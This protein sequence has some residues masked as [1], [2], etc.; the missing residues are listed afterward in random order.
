MVKIAV[1]GWY[2]TETIGDRA[3]LA[4]L[5]KLIS[6]SCPEFEL[7][8][9]SLYPVVSER[10]LYEDISFYKQCSGDEKLKIELFNTSRIK[11]LDC[12]IN[13]ADLVVIGGGP[14]MDTLP[15]YMLKYA[16]KKAKR[17]KK[18]TAI[19]GCGLGPLTKQKYINIALST[20]S[21]SDLVIFRDEKS[22][23]LYEEFQKPK[24]IKE[25]FSAIDPAVFA[26][27]EFL[28]LEKNAPKKCQITVNFREIL[29]DV[30]AGV[31][32]EEI[33]K[34]LVEVVSKIALSTEKK[35]LLI[36]MHTVSI[37]GD[38]RFIL[39]KIATKVALPNV[40]VQNKPLSLEETMREYYQSEYCVGM[41][42]HSILL[43]MI[44]NGR[45]YIL[46][47]TDPQKGKIINLLEQF[48][49]SKAYLNRYYS[50]INNSGEV[51]FDF[52]DTPKVNI[53]KDVIMEF[54][55]LYKEKIANL[56]KI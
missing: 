21:H 41:R 12:A 27:Q 30:F 44:L 54:E 11:E 16:F 42:F 39:N 56:L 38:D 4:G 36:P 40:E 35:V 45:N 7:R 48:D 14:L 2:G 17:E 32:T 8:L 26:A 37:G 46:D 22:K 50:L 3:I 15:M 25:V 13:W 18:K 29:D 49:L 1:I 34:R 5:L 23:M 6:S 9:G 19:L 28:K 10:T 31:I 20:I 33:E 47:Y 43:Q 24:R 55:Q 53:S 52:N 51:L